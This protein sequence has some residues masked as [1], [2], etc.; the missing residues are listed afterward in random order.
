M[1]GFLTAI[2]MVMI[3]FGVFGIGA[4]QASAAAG[5]APDSGDE[6]V[7]TSS[8]NRCWVTIAKKGKK[9]VKCKSSAAYRW[10]VH[11]YCFD[12][13]G[14]PKRICLKPYRAHK[15]WSG[16]KH[17]RNCQLSGF[18]RVSPRAGVDAGAGG[19]AQQPRL[20]LAVAGMTLFTLGSGLGLAALRRRRASEN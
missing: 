3:G 18:W 2:L 1:R 16:G 6:S 15:C 8:D 13:N 20:G 7:G 10:Y 19:T 5:K 9:Q 14:T 11:N 12:T 17:T 4:T